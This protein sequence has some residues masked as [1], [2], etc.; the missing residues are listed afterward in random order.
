MIKAQ[1]ASLDLLNDVARRLSTPATIQQMESYPV[2]PDQGPQQH[3][4]GF[5]SF[6]QQKQLEKDEKE[7]AAAAAAVERKS[8]SSSKQSQ[9]PLSAYGMAAAAAQLA[10]TAASPFQVVADC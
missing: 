7:A 4:F 9:A 1:R 6:E 5:D 10:S 8:S 2:P 3:H